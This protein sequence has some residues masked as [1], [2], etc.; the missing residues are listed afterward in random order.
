MPAHKLGQVGFEPHA[1]RALG[2][3]AHGIRNIQGQGNVLTW[4]LHP[5]PYSGYPGPQN[6]FSKWLGACT[7]CCTVLFIGSI[8]LSTNCAAGMYTLRLEERSIHYS[9]VLCVGC[10]MKRTWMCRLKSTHRYIR[11]LFATGKN[12]EW[13]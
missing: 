12:Q 1:S 13:V 7:K 9:C 4:S 3:A 6:S 11:P 5:R 2:R 8:V 10:D